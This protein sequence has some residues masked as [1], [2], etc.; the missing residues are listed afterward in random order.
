MN[1]NTA[2]VGVWPEPK[3]LT[4]Y[5]YVIIMSNVCVL[6]G[7]T[8]R[9]ATHGIS[10][11][12]PF[13]SEGVTSHIYLCRVLRLFVT[14]PQNGNRRPSTM[15]S[16]TDE[17]NR[18]MNDTTMPPPRRLKAGSFDLD[19]PMGPPPPRRKF[20]LRKGFGLQDWVKLTKSAKDLAQRKGAPLRQITPAEVRQHSKVNDGWF[21]L[22]GKVYNIGPYL[23]YHPGGEAILKKILGSDAT[24]LFDKYHRWVNID[25]LVGVL[26]V[27]YLDTGSS[28]DEEDEMKPPAYLSQQKHQDECEY[29]F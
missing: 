7:S 9:Y 8:V 15:A 20:G 26:Q 28:V 29:Y 18:H 21:S 12:I 19:N 4:M 27:G 11:P 10:C 13:D 5:E 14:L 25:G 24:A 17:D 3:F 22:K 23:P 6:G 2:S 16:N 1:G